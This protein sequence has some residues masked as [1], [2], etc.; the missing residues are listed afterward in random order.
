MTAVDLA[1]IVASIIPPVGAVMAIARIDAELKHRA[2]FLIDGRIRGDYVGPAFDR[3]RDAITLIRILNGEA[4]RSAQASR[5]TADDLAGTGIPTSEDARLSP[6]APAPQ[7]AS[8]S[9][10]ACPGCGGPLPPGRRNQDRRTCSDRC[11]RRVARRAAEEAARL[12]QDGAASSV[13]PSRPSEAEPHPGQL[14][15]ARE[16]AGRPPVAPVCRAG[17]RRSKRGRRA[18]AT[19]SHLPHSR[20]GIKALGVAGIRSADAPPVTADASASRQFSLPRLTPSTRPGLPRWQSP[21]PF[22]DRSRHRASRPRSPS[23]GGV[24]AHKRESE[25]PH[26]HTHPPHR[27]HHRR[28]ASW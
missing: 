24:G 23:S 13:T 22:P 1:R 7:E 12:D 27:R 2:A 18:R 25:R 26:G 19:H 15:S 21:D 9:L 14:R 16:S 10:G 17:A 5:T 6:E 20:P 3:P 4:P 28:H 11:R 8:L